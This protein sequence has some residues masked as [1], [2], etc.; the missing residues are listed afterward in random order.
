MLNSKAWLS[1]YLPIF[2]TSEQTSISDAESGNDQF[3]SHEDSHLLGGTSGDAP[4]FNADLDYM[5]EIDNISDLEGE[6]WDWS[7]D[8]EKPK[9]T[10]Q[11]EPVLLPDVAI[12][13]VDTDFLRSHSTSAA[14]CKCSPPDLSS[15]IFFQWKIPQI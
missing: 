7:D 1:K 15:K 8:D 5:T 13:P 10:I 2:R 9:G 3:S 12:D 11:D 4:K 6:A 14:F